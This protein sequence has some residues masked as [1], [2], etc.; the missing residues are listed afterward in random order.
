MSKLNWGMFSHV[1]IDTGS[2]NI[3]LFWYLNVCGNQGGILFVS[4]SICLFLFLYGTVKLPGLDNLRFD[5][6]VVKS[7][8]GLKNNNLVWDTDFY[9]C[10]FGYK[11]FSWQC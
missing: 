1:F 9:D 10:K 2:S 4:E 7:K 8:T 11:T 6:T 3:F 5:I